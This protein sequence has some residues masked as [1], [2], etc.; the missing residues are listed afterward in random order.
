M[1]K[2]NEIFYS[3]QGESSAAGL[4]TTFVRLTGCNLR[5]SY[6]DTEYAFYEGEDFTVEEAIRKAEE[7][8]CKLVEVTG[9]E[10]LMQKDVI[11]FMTQLCDKGFDVMLETS[12][13][14]QIEKVDKRVKIVMDLKTPSSGMEKKNLYSNIDFLKSK[15]EVKFVIGSLDDYNWAKRMIEKFNLTGKTEVLFSPVFNAIEPKQI[16]EWML[17]DKLNIRFQLQ[18]HKYIW[19]PETR[20]V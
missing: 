13:S 10:P 7:Y 15:D 14:L 18:M 6:C 2:I 8:G 3:I 5:C 20:G 11:P 1:L 9:G 17:N 19:E 12:G 16:V 4:P